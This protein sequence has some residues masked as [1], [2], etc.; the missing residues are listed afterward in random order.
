MGALTD[1]HM[2]WQWLFVAL[3]FASVVVGVFAIQRSYVRRREQSRLRQ[4]I[5]EV[6]SPAA[7]TALQRSSKASRWVDSLYRLSLPSEGWSEEE[8]RIKFLRAGFR[9]DQAPRIHLA[10][11]TALVIVLPLL[12]LLVLTFADVHWDSQRRLMVA[13]LAAAVAYY[14]PD[15]Y[16][17]WRTRSRQLQMQQG[18]PDLVDLMVVALEAGMGLDQAMTRVARELVRSHPTLSEEFY[19]A[20]LEVRAGVARAAAMKNLAQRVNLEDLSALITM[21]NQSER[22][23]T[24]LGESLRIQSEVMRMRRGQRAEEIAAKIPIKMLFPL[25]FCIFPSIMV[26]LVGPGWMRITEAFRFA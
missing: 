15:L 7:A 5:G 22:F 9:S 12:V 18:L 23:G 20:G 26:V 16:L 25:I 19:L 17:H 6:Q 11:K 21:I 4:L 2:L 8:G 13:L 3:V 10:L 24:S 1:R 14:G